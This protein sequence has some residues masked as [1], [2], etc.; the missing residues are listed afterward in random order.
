VALS[1]HYRSPVLL[2][3]FDADRPFSLESRHEMSADI[4]SRSAISKLVLVTLHFPRVRML[5]S[6]G[7]HN[8][9]ALFAALKKEQAEPDLDRAVLVGAEGETGHA[10]STLAQEILRAL[11]GVTDHNVLALLNH[12]KNLQELC[13]MPLEALSRLIGQVPATKLHAFL[14]ADLGVL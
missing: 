1:R 4:S 9:A 5:W 2:I 8:T 6:H 14:H 12:V 13:Q 10:V 7:P 11:P 3:E